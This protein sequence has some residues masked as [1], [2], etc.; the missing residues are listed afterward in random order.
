MQKNTKAFTFFWK[1]LSHL[2]LEKK[3]CE[4]HVMKNSASIF[5]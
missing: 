1:G 2:Q 4:G 3:N 5:S